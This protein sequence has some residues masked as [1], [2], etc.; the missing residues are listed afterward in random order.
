MALDLRDF[1]RRLQTGIEIAVASSD[2]DRLLGVREG[3]LRYFHEGLGRRTPVA[4]V[5]HGIE[6][7]PLGLPL[8]DEATVALARRQAEE[9]RSR[10][11]EAYQF[12]VG[13]QPGLTSL[14]VGGQARYFIRLWAVVL[15]PGGEAWGGS[16]S[17]QLPSDAVT[18]VRDGELGLSLGTRKQGGIISSLTGGLEGRRRAA[19]SATF[20]ALCSLYYGVLQARPGR[21]RD[22][23]SG[24]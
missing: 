17:L 10:L 1:P 16:G 24:V 23:L 19:A 4:V 5:A 8:T 21:S 15:G 6:E 2:S 12:Y 14:E 20:K 9:L 3:F 18:G 22:E 13:A 7:P 11:G